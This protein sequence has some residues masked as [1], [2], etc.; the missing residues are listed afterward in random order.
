MHLEREIWGS[1]LV[2]NGEI[3]LDTLKAAGSR[4]TVF[5]KEKEIQKN[6]LGGGG[7]PRFFQPFRQFA[8][9]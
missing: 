4:N 2:K 1:V 7:C 6:I 9:S 3:R 8:H 5:M